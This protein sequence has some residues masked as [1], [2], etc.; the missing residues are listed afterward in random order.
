MKELT[1]IRHLTTA[2]T[3]NKDL[4]SVTTNQIAFLVSFLELPTPRTSP[5]AAAC[6]ILDISFKSSL[7]IPLTRTSFLSLSLFFFL[8]L[9][10]FF[11]LASPTN[12][13]FIR[14]HVLGRSLYHPSGTSFWGVQLKNSFNTS[15]LS[16][17]SYSVREQHRALLRNRWEKTYPDIG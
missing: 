17:M 2:K 4:Q 16:Y 8:S 14:T 3:N 11:I 9:S 7:P 15:V 5:H 13:V 12:N 10:L 1:Y 6:Q